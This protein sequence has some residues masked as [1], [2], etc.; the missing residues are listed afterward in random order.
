MGALSILGHKGSGL[1]IGFSDFVV[2]QVA[3]QIERFHSMLKNT[4]QR[5]S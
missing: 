5:W 4:A 3:K 2:M 1:V